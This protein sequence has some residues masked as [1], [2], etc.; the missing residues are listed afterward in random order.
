M[1]DK[2]LL[3][4]QKLDTAAEQLRHRYEHLPERDARME[5]LAKVE[6]LTNEVAVIGVSRL[7]VAARQK[8]FEDEAQI[9]EAKAE[10]DNK[11]LY[12]GE[13]GVKELQPLQDEIA[14]LR[15]RQGELETHALETMEE[16]EALA[17]RLE[18]TQATKAATEERETVLVAE[19][20]TL[21]TEIDAELTSVLA[22]R[23]AAVALVNAD[24][25]TH[26][27]KLRPGMGSATV[28]VF[29]GA[30]C[31][32]CPS[33]M[34]AMELDR[35]KHSPSGSVLSCNECGRIVLN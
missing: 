12:S 6:A 35:M 24:D 32:G 28:V 25:L 27:E 5:A 8:R 22:D 26:Y 7:E 14:G 15:E 11:R 1:S 21:E 9:F 16:A 13:V 17:T 34:P 23:E 2:P 30:N 4:I 29:D 33:A 10:E 31:A 19:I 3:D 18:E 20:A